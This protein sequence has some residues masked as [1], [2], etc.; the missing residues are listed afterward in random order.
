M[1]FGLV[2]HVC[3]SALCRS[4]VGWIC[5]LLIPG[6]TAAL[7]IPYLISLALLT[8]TMIPAFPASPRQM[9]RL[10]GKLDHA[11][12]SLLQGVDIDTGHALPGFRTSRG[13]SGTEKVRIKS[14]VERSRVCVVDVMAKGEF[15]ED[16]EAGQDDPVE[17]DL[18]GDLIL[19]E[20]DDMAE[21]EDWTLA[22]GKVYDRT[23]VEIG[24]TMDG[25]AIG[26]RTE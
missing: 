9:F 2:E 23:L 6:H 13:V 8:T 16:D 10:L 4:S 7:Q 20:V 5:N 11:F 21:A 15:D 18:E 25:P 19:E 24:D 26:I 1:W 12:A 22:V 3:I 14:L 17:S